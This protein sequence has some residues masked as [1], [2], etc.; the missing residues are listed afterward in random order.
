MHLMCKEKLPA[1]RRPHQLNGKNSIAGENNFT[2]T[3]RHLLSSRLSISDCP[4][5]NYKHRCTCDDCSLSHI[6]M[7]GIMDSPVTDGVHNDQ[8]PL[9]IDSTPDYLSEIHLPSVSSGSSG[10]GSSSPF[11]VQQLDK[12]RLILTDNGSGSTFNIEDEEAAPISEKL[13]DIYS[14]NNYENAK[15]VRNAT[16]IHSELNDRVEN[17]G[18]KFESPQGSSSSSSSSETDAEEADGSELP[19]TQES[20]LVLERNSIRKDEAKRDGSRPS[21]PTQQADRGSACCECHVCNQEVTGT[22]SSDT[23]VS[24]LPTGHQFRNPEKPAHPA[25]HLYPHIHGQMHTIP[26][27]TPPLIH[28]SLYTASTY[29]QNKALVQNHTNKHQGLS[30]SLQDHIYPSCFGSTA[31]WKSSKFLSIWG[32]EVMNEK[33]WNASTFLQDTFPGEGSDIVATTCSDL[34]PNALPVPSR[35][36]G[37]LVMDSKKRENILKKKCLYHFQD[38]FMDANKVVMA[39]SSATSSVSCTATTVQSSNNQ[40]K[41]SSKTSSSLGDVFHSHNSED[42]RCT[43]SPGLQSNSTSLAPLSSLSPVMLS[44]ASSP[45]LPSPNVQSFSR[46]TTTGPGFVDPHS[47]LYP[48]TIVPPSATDSLISAPPSVCSDPDC[49]GHHCDNSNIYDHQ[50]YDGEES[51]DEDSCSEHSSG[52]STSTNQ[53]EG[54][55]CDCCYCEFFGHGGP[56][57]APTSRNYAEMREKLRLRLTKRKEEQPKKPE[58]ISDRENV[59]DHRKVEDLLQFINSPETKPVSSTR[60]AKRARHKQKKLK[61]K[62]SIETEVGEREHHEPHEQQPEEDEEGQQLQELQT[63]K[64]KKKERS[65]TNCQK[66]KVLPQNGQVVSKSLPNTP[67]SIQNEALEQIETS[68]DLLS[69]IEEGSASVNFCDPCNPVNARDSNLLFK[70]EMT[71]KSHEPLSLLLNIMHNHTEEKNNQKIT[72]ISKLFA[73]QLKKPSKA[74]NIH[75]KINK[76]MQSKAKVEEIQSLAVSKKEKRG[77]SNNTK[78]MT[79]V[80]EPPF[81]SSSPSPSE[82]HHKTILQDVPLPKGKSKKNKKKKG[83]KVN[84]SIDDVFLPKDVDLDNV[85]MDETE[86]EVEYFKRFCLDSARQTRQRL[87]INWSNFS[88]KKA[89]FAAH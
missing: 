33:D 29:T 76:E 63:M 25:L 20:D 65:T 21:Y 52:T 17:V 86:R 37:T 83:D 48:T 34:G 89:T 27:L 26:H 49:E 42:H 11:T 53:K 10:S 44:P 67:E 56:P 23:N 16:R 14:I 78:Q 41:V 51:Q 8:L 15:I 39:T 71:V 19:R 31:D 88:L 58:L 40:F 55:Y 30:T 73:Q 74:T 13:A 43:S 59:I 28:P 54:K 50:Q 77:N 32:S 82:Q 69:N 62:A 87:S 24:C 70:T 9:Q 2:D 4:N 64:E 72:Q 84:S 75:P 5:C 47:G 12:P 3:M 22:S 36:E 6:L 57:A 1:L 85:D 68:M 61:G 79:P 60:A 38:A 35:N 66:V 80:T 18:L 45:H 81:V 46:V 7:C